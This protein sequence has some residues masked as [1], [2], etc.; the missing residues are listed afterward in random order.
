MP[1]TN[2]RDVT[3]CSLVTAERFWGSVCRLSVRH[4]APAD[5]SPVRRLVQ[6]GGVKV[7]RKGEIHSVTGHKG[8][9]GEYSCSSTLSLTSGL[10]ATPRP[11]YPRERPGTHCTGGWV[12]PRAGLDGCGK[13]R[14][15]TGIRY[16]DRPARSESLYRLSYPGPQTVFGFVSELHR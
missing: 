3:P 15:P 1:V 10:N 2:L 8:P 16:P 12:G 11:L 9:E 4:T 14:P 7:K 6:C 13:S 5:P